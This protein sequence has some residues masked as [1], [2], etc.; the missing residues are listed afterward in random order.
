MKK[1]MKLSA[2]STG[3]SKIKKGDPDMKKDKP[4]GD[5]WSKGKKR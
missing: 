3:D 2:K 1:P 4:K 5:T